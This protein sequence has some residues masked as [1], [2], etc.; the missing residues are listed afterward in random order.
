MGLKYWNKF[1]LWQEKLVV[2][3]NKIAFVNIALINMIWQWKR[4]HVIILVNGHF[5]IY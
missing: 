1:I 3:D 2:L 5:N 4:K